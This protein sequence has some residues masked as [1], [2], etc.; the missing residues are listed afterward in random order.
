MV[1]CVNTN[2]ESEKRFQALGEIFVRYVYEEN[3]QV[4]L[5]NYWIDINKSVKKYKYKYSPLT[6]RFNEKK[7]GI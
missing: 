7:K 2:K 6:C 3:K 5:N 4:K 1:D